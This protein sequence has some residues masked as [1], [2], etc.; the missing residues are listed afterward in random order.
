VGGKLIFNCIL[1]KYDEVIWIGFIW[2]RIR[3]NGVLLCWKIL[4][5]LKD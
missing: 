1:E 4:A 2:L 5:C 3:T